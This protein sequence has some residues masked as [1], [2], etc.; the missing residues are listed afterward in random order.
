MLGVK[1][2]NRFSRHPSVGQNQF[3]QIGF[4]LTGV[5]ENENIGIGFVIGTLIK[6]RYDV[7]TEF[8]LAEIKAIFVCF[9][10]VVERKQ[11]C[12]CRCRKDT[13]ILRAEDIIATRH[14]GDEAFLLPHGQMID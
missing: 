8:I 10:G 1:T 4:A 14:T 13:L 5:A 12:D 11:V 2:D 6:V 9:A 7:G 3:E